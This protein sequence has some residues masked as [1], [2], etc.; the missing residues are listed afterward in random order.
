MSGLSYGI[1]IGQ[2]LF[3]WFFSLVLLFVVAL[4]LDINWAKPQLQRLMADALHR[5]VALGK[6]SWNLGFDGLAI[7]SDKMAITEA[8]GQPF[9][10]A[11]K[12]EVGIAFLPLFHKQMIIHYLSFEKPELWALYLGN[13][14]WNFS[15]LLANQLDIR[16]IQLNDGK[17]HLADFSAKENSQLKT[18]AMQ[19]VSF[20]KWPA[21]DLQDVKLNFVWP[22]KGHRWPFYTS[23]T[24]PRKGYNTY[25][26]LTALGNGQLADWQSNKYHVDFK[27]KNLN[28][29]DLSPFVAI[30]AGNK[31]LLDL[32][33]N[34]EGIYQKGMKTKARASVSNLS[35]SVPKLGQLESKQATVAGNVEF[36]AKT[37]AWNNLKINLA[38]VEVE[39]QGRLENCTGQTL[40][41]SQ[42]NNFG[43]SFFNKVEALFPWTKE[44]QTNVFLAEQKAHPGLIGMMEF[45]TKI[46]ANNKQESVAEIV[47]NMLHG[48]AKVHSGLTKFVDAI[49]GAQAQGQIRLYHQ[50]DKIEVTNGLF[51]L[52]NAELK[53][54]STIDREKRICQLSYS[55]VDLPLQAFSHQ[56]NLYFNSVGG[57]NNKSL[58]QHLKGAL[59]TLRTEGKIDLNGQSEITA[60]SCKTK[61]DAE[62]KDVD[63]AIADTPGTKLE[64]HKIKGKISY[65]DDLLVMDK[66][67]GIIGGGKFDLNGKIRQTRVPDYHLQFASNYMELVYLNRL[68]ALMEI[69]FPLLTEKQLTGRVQDLDLKINGPDDKPVIALGALCQDLFYQPPGMTIP[70]HAIAGQI[71]Y[72]NDDLKLK[73]L[74]FVTKS[75]KVTTSLDINHLST[76]PDLLSA[77]ARTSN[78]DLAE[79]NYYLA[80]PAIPLSLRKA[81]T[82][83]LASNQLS[84][85]NGKIYGFLDW[86]QAKDN[87]LQLHAVI[88]LN[89]ASASCG[90]TKLPLQKVS[91]TFIAQDNNLVVN[92][93]H[94]ALGSSTFVINGHGQN[95]L[96][97]DINLRSDITAEIMP[98][99]LLQLLPGLPANV[100]SKLLGKLGGD[101]TISLK[102]K[103]TQIK[104][105]K[106]IVFLLHADPKDNFK[107]DS[108]LLKFYQPQGQ[109]VSLEGDLSLSPGN[110]A[111]TSGH[112][113][114]GKEEI[115]AQGSY[116]WQANSHNQEPA[117]NLE[118][119][120]NQPMKLHYLQN[121]FAATPSTL[122]D[123]I[124]GAVSGKVHI[125]GTLDKVIASA[126]LAL[127]NVNVPALNVSKASG[128]LTS[129]YWP[130]LA[131]PGNE[132]ADGSVTFNLQS[133]T[134]GTTN[135]QD[136]AATIIEDES[137]GKRPKVN[138]QNCSFNVAGGKVNLHGLAN[139]NNNSVHSEITFANIDAN[140][141]LSQAFAIPGE[142]TG[143]ASGELALDTQGANKAELISHLN[144]SGQLNIAAGKVTRFGLLQNKITQSNLVH[145][146]LFGFN[147]NNLLQS[148]APVRS[149]EF[150]HLTANFYVVNGIVT[151]QDLQFNGDDLRLWAAGRFSLPAN[152]MTMEV[153]GSFPRVSSSLLSSTVGSMSRNFTIQ[154]FVDVATMHKLQGLPSLP[155]L[156]D[157]ASDSPRAF[158]FNVMASLNDANNVS[159]SIEKSFHW[160]PTHANASA[161]PV[162][163]I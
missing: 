92:G 50:N 58:S 10:I 101:S 54:G 145:E 131:A 37:V 62:L 133:L 160:L 147:L 35:W 125:K 66:L 53:W 129:A 56:L 32:D 141:F 75:G 124:D 132:V 138:V 150:K 21:Y 87:N 143:K 16:F 23:F 89:G 111:L 117:I 40:P 17:V 105:Q 95:Y 11:G 162:P 140:T 60:S 1:V 122:D 68:L 142:L 82:G 27:S 73:D 119:T 8:D 123:A 155:L 100:Q 59:P 28:I 107:I 109:D 51:T 161:H 14:R 45:K 4:L 149:G 49:E 81:Y 159:K 86:H 118:L 127:N 136:L 39:S 126:N 97:P 96:N 134:L 102:A 93:L 57:S 157:I 61:V 90:Q 70:L 22:K 148:V 114:I 80:S 18:F 3:A 72:D 24:L 25:I 120:A 48:D 91:G 47:A 135:L 38:N 158:S 94:G 88:G 13:K 46:G 63:L 29:E 113:K 146:G 44:H 112:C 108:P 163:S 42:T 151:S 55:G 106:D 104:E 7:G 144:G 2:F 9:L 84:D 156:G 20:S 152:T 110:Y 98:S 34:A 52:N 69:Q 79:L 121:T 137:G 76:A 130:I 128:H 65:T 77:K 33:L 36:D 78:I 19:P 154:R 6:L 64:A 26:S 153:D 85:L 31:G 67:S 74:Q 139:L 30:D 41:G 43:F 71:N 116:Q 5:K 99:E 103:L 83:F 12:S 115:D 15:D